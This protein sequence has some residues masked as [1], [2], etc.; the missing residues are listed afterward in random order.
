MNDLEKLAIIWEDI[1]LRD[2]SIYHQP[3]GSCVADENRRGC[4]GPLDVALRAPGAGLV[5]LFNDGL[6]FHRCSLPIRI[7]EAIQLRKPTERGG[8]CPA[9]KADMSIPYAVALWSR[10][11]SQA[12]H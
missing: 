5:E 9:L 11:S 8:L 7:A 3:R 10:R 1:R 12:G 2:R 6:K 4:S